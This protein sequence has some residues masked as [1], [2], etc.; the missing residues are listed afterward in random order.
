MR[1][2]EVYA[3]DENGYE[4][5]YEYIINDSDSMYTHVLTW[6]FNKTALR[7]PNGCLVDVYI[8]RKSRNPWD[9][10]YSSY[11]KFDIWLSG[12]IDVK[13]IMLN[14]IN[15]HNKSYEERRLE[16]IRRSQELEECR[17]RIKR[18]EQEKCMK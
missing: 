1:I 9:F 6:G 5:I 2:L 16:Y 7:N 11:S 13:G 3:Y 10:D 17:E 15:K 8:N 12:K 14:R 18:M 4:N